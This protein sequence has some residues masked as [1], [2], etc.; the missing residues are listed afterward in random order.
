ME[1]GFTGG[2]KGGGKTLQKLQKQVFVLECVRTHTTLLTIDKSKGDFQIP[3]RFQ[4]GDILRVKSYPAAVWMV[5]G[6]R[7]KVKG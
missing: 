2:G 6:G 5:E 7:W 4:Q 1:G 3:V